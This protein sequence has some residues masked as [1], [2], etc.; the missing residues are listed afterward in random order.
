MK[1][2]IF[3]H[4][5]KGEYVGGDWIN[6]T[7][8]VC[9]A[10]PIASKS[11]DF[12]IKGYEKVQ[13]MDYY[14][15]YYDEGGEQ[16]SREVPVERKANKDFFKDA[17]PLIS[18]PGGFQ[19]GQYAYPFQYHLPDN[20][21]GCFRKKKS[22]KYSYQAKIEYKVKA[23]VDVP[24][25]PN[26]KIK[27]PLVV[28]AKLDKAIAAQHFNKKMEVRTCCVIPRGPVNCEAWM[29]KNCYMAGEVAQVHVKVHNESAVKVN[30]F[31]TKLIR[32]LV[33]KDEHG[34]TKKLDDVVCMQK[35]DGTN[36]KSKKET[37]C[38]LPLKGKKD[39]SI[40]PSSESKYIKCKYEAMIA[41]DIPLAPD[42]EIITPVIIYAPQ[43]AMWAN[44]A[45]PSWASTATVVNEVNPQ[46]AVKNDNAQHH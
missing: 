38:P 6:G 33:F 11:L 32:H 10:E 2:E 26:L 45:P 28:N 8:Y 46:F 14:T 23:I 39:K 4:T 21:P 24:G 22:G 43:N 17:L 41:L 7:V 5:D 13:W 12:E 36:P 20:L 34:N 19:A 15:E 3:I 44:W 40:R 16:R 29:D 30:H 35:Y 1:N 27:Q 37:D 42:L 25:A 9:I 31:N 18:Y